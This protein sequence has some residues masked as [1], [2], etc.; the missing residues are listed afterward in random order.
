MKKRIMVAAALFCPAL[1]WAQ[2]NA[3]VYGL[4]DIYLA[5]TRGSTNNVARGA[6]TVVNSG[7]LNTSFWGVKGSEKIGGLTAEFALEGFFR[8]DTGE[9]GRSAT[10]PLFG[11]NAF[12][13]LSGGFGRLSAGRQTSLFY[14]SAGNLNPFGTSTPFSPAVLLVYRPLGTIYATAPLAG[15]TAWSNTLRYSTVAWKGLQA[16]LMLQASEGAAGALDRNRNRGLSSTVTYKLGK[17]DT[18]V[19]YQ[20]LNLE[21]NNDGHEQEAGY[22]GAAY[23]FGAV[24]LFAQLYR[25]EDSYRAAIS[26][27]QHDIAVAGLGVPVGP[28][29]VLAGYGRTNTE[30]SRPGMVDA[31]RTT[32]TLGYDHPLSK[33]TD[34]YAIARRDR[35]DRGA[36]NAKDEVLALGIRHLF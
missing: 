17:F 19:G 8:G 11:K 28:G 1:A 15:D 32:W 36:L 10:D 16:N 29:K 23:D 33:R 18:A 14:I 5:K 2:S 30:Y 22:L 4:F 6:A 35:A 24:K 9:G 21:A 20:R 34:V 3:S 27:S 25:I 7:G 13:A 12:V 26:D 31:H